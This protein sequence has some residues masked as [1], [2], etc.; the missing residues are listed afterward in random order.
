MKV[1]VTGGRD[2][3]GVQ[4]VWSVLERLHAETP[5]EMLIEGGAS[6]AD[7]H[8][9]RWAIRR[10]IRTLT[11][12]VSK[13][14]WAQFGKAAG[15]MRNARMLKAGQPDL[16]VAFPGHDGTADMVAKARAAGVRVIEEPRPG[17]FPPRSREDGELV[18]QGTRSFVAPDQPRGKRDPP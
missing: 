14:E 16:V 11:Y 8:A 7:Q 17:C 18:T 6:G 5:I 9:R 4:H 10:D 13:A 12:G 2:Y 3:P 1:L 15:P